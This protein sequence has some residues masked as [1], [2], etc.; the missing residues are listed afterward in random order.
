MNMIG[1]FWVDGTHPWIAIKYEFIYPKELEFND[2]PEGVTLFAM[3]TAKYRNYHGLNNNSQSS[4]Q[5]QDKLKVPFEEKFK[6]NFEFNNK[7]RERRCGILAT[8]SVFKMVLNLKDL[9]T[10]IA[11]H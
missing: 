3:K 9:K 11:G 6:E 4:S 5:K 1:K 2:I 10:N 8:D 7:L